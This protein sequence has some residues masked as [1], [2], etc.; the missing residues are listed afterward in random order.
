[1]GPTRRNPCRPSD[2]LSEIRPAYHRISSRT[3]RSRLLT[4]SEHHVRDARYRSTRQSVLRSQEQ[5]LGPAKPRE[6]PCPQAGQDSLFELCNRVE[7]VIT[8]RYC[9][10][11]KDGRKF[12][13]ND[14][15]GYDGTAEPRAVGAALIEPERRR[16]TA[17]VDT[18]R[19]DVAE[20]PV[21]RG[22]RRAKTSG[23][24]QTDRGHLHWFLCA[25]DLSA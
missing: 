7:S 21:Q 4:D 24:G 3:G 11:L 22:P 10:E 9:I 16:K 20:R 5:R 2:S 1:M 17:H 25:S 19:L 18:Q 12:P 23:L 6:Q 15:R 14:E 8:D 13:R